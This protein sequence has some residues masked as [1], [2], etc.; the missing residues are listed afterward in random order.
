M[1]FEF[2]LANSKVELYIYIPKSIKY[3]KIIL[4]HKKNKRIGNK[5]VL[6]KE[7]SVDPKQENQILKLFL[8]GK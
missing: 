1:I 6:I 5:S 8:V 7:I 4:K 3:K 2:L